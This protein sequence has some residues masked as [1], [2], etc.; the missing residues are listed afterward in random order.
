VQPGRFSAAGALHGL[1][2]AVRIAT[3]NVNSLGVRLDQVLAFAGSA[4][5]DL[6]ALQE[7]KLPDERFPVA[8]IEAAGYRTLFSGQKTYNGVALL[9]RGELTE[10]SREIVGEPDPQRRWLAA[11][12][13]GVRV[14]DVYVP[15]GESVRSP[16]Y[17]YKL[18][19]M[20]RLCEGIAAELARHRELV[21]LGDF[22][23]APEPR[24]VYDPRV[25][26]GNVMFS[27]PER[28]ALRKL[29]SLGLHDLFRRFEQPEQEFSWW[30]YRMGAFRRNRGLRIDLILASDALAARC[31]ACRIDKEPR[32]HERPSD[33]APV[34]ADFA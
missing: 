8:E 12:Y 2:E 32:R 4:R 15:N 16:K 26:E 20:E 13:Q 14:I 18:G 22:N 28:E 17:A 25:W 7:T 27:E 23:I 19:W 24:D 9:A 33:H 1:G 11:C 6:F 34:I 30:D 10:A 29:T 31:T 21:V 5:P 3:W